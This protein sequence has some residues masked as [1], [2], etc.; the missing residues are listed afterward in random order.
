MILSYRDLV[1]A[2]K[3][4]QIRFTPDIVPERQIGLSSIDLRL[5]TVFARLK[6]REGLIVQPARGFDPTDHV[7][8]QDTAG[9][10]FVSEGP[11]FRLAPGA[12][13]LAFTLEEVAL[14]ADLAANVRVLPARVRELS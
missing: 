11:I 9:A 1:A 12:F 6:P 14:P 3:K 7:E 13:R 5:G 4:K 2:W 8:I 10:S